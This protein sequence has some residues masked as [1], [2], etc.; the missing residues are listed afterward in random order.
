LKGGEVADNAA[1][2][3]RIFEGERGAKTDIV[4]LNA[5]AAIMLGRG[6]DNL[7]AAIKA[8]RESLT[9]GAALKKL[10][11]L[12]ESPKLRREMG[13]YNRAMVEEKFKLERMVNEY[14]MLF[15]ETLTG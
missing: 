4:I 3:R 13:E 7:N 2:I 5:A 10:N 14:Q 12:A 15:E 1:I 8:A 6:E 9:S 11:L